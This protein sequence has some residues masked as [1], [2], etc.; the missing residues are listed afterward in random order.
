MP[1][2]VQIPENKRDTPLDVADA[3]K[4]VIYQK[5]AL[6]YPGNFHHL[7]GIILKTNKSNSKKKGIRDRQIMYLILSKKKVSIQR[8]SL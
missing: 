5:I 2:S 4:K 6:P 8:L 3:T 7:K 1:M